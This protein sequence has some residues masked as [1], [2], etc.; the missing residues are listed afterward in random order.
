M[1]CSYEIRMHAICSSS[2]RIRD[3]SGWRVGHTRNH[4]VLK[5]RFPPSSSGR[6]ST[7]DKLTAGQLL[8]NRYEIVREFLICRFSTLYHALDRTMGLPVVIRLL[9]LPPTGEAKRLS[10]MRV[11]IEREGSL[12][13]QLRHPNLP[14]VLQIAQD[15]E[16]FF[17]V[18]EHFEGR[19]LDIYLKEIGVIPLQALYQLLRQF[20]YALDYL[21]S[22]TPPIIHRDLRP[23]S[24]VLTSNGVLKIAEFGLARI[25]EPGDPSTTRFRSEGSSNYA[26]PEQLAR[27]PSSPANDIYALGCIMYFLLTHEHPPKSMERAMN[28]TPLRAMRECSPQLPPALEAIILRMMEPPRTKRYTTAK[29][30]EAD[31]LVHF[32]TGL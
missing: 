6:Q 1:I 16:R 17:L 24:V 27:S 32:P 11:Q 26:A 12:L 4:F 2:I 9:R 28:E 25:T 18:L 22:Q 14:A 31:L 19:T 3:S 5:R 15:G 8:A 23:H 10:D 29:E 30:V 13:A 20:L 21:H 7:V